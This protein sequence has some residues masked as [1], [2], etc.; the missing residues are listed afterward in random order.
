M[1]FLEAA[2]GLALFGS[3][4]L[5]LVALFVTH[6]ARTVM[7]CRAIERAYRLRLQA[8]QAQAARLETS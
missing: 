3:F 2:I 7:T 8:W 4:Q 5:L 6:I 1:E